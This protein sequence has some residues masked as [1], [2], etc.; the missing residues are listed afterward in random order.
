[1]KVLLCRVSHAVSEHFG[2]PQHVEIF[3]EIVSLHILA[4]SMISMDTWEKVLNKVE[5]KVG[6][7]SYNTWFKPTQFMQPGR[8][9]SLYPRS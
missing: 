9:C 7:Q 6:P 2:F 4:V 3:V 5:E 8:L 1:M